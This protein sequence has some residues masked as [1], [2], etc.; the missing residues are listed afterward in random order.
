MS[1]QGTK[2]RFGSWLLTQY[3][4]TYTKYSKLST[5]KKSKIQD[6]YQ[7]RKKVEAKST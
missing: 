3:R 7:G 1:R 4:M 6:E 2:D 5:E